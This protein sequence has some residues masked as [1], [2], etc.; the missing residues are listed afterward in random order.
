MDQN[1]SYV[2]I[3]RSIS[4]SLCI[5]CQCSISERML[6]LLKKLSSLAKNVLSI[7]LMWSGSMTIIFFGFYLMETI[8]VPYLFNWKNLW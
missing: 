4:D 8:N 3:C 2:H 7:L 6:C 1:I 5:L